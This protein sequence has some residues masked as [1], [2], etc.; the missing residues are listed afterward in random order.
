MIKCLVGL[1]AQLRGLT[2]WGSERMKRRQAPRDTTT[3]KL[4]LGGTD[5]WTSHSTVEAQ[6]IRHNWMGKK[7]CCIQLN[8]EVGLANYCRHGLWR[9]AV[10]PMNIWGK[11]VTVDVFCSLCQRGCHVHPHT[12]KRR[13]LPSV[14][15]LS[16]VGDVLPLWW[17]WETGILDKAIPIS[18]NGHSLKT[19]LTCLSTLLSSHLIVH[20]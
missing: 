9:G 10:F 18:N 15:D 3:E 16:Q 8:Q 13:T 11:K 14:W 20:S 17:T 12:D 4:R 7:G 5:W 1:S 19:S 6:S 2:C